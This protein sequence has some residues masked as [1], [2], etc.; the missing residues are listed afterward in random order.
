MRFDLPAK[1]PFS[2]S[3]VIH[4]HGWANLAPFQLDSDQNQLSYIYQLKD[5]RVVKLTIEEI[6]S[7]VAVEVND[8]LNSQ[9]KGEISTAVSWMLAL[10]QDF[11]EF[12][13]LAKDEPKLKHVVKNAQGRLL[14]SPTLFEDIVKTILTTNTAWSGT[15]RMAE[16]L[17]NQFGD[18]LPGDTERH[19][20]P[21][22]DSIAACDE[23]TL[24]EKAR[25]GYRSPYMLNL[26][27]EIKSANLELETLKTAD[28]PTEEIRNQLLAIKGVGNYAAANLLMLLGRYNHLA[29]DSWAMKMVSHEWYNNEPIGPNEVEQAFKKWGEWK[30][31]AYWFWDWSGDSE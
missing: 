7:G 19:A 5:K 12:Y 13:E 14:R 28:T 6:P 11:A 26:A 25:L 21:T 20:F 3:S 24:R 31:L 8:S 29:I 16:A 4:S 1:K 2:L 17:V 10:D 27:Q 15:I 30:G 18:P 22:V 9:E 23:N